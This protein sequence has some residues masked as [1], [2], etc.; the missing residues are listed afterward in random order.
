MCVRAL[1]HPGIGLSGPTEQLGSLRILRSAGRD[2]A[3]AFRDDVRAGFSASPKSLPP[4][5]FYDD[6]G[7]CLFEAICRLPEYYLTRAENEILREH[8]PAILDRA[9]RAS[10]REGWLIELGAGSAL[11]TR[12]LIGALMERGAPLHYVPIDIS[13]AELERT[14]RKLLGA[15]PTLRVT[16]VAAEFEAALT[17]LE[18][19]TRTRPAGTPTLALFLGSTIGNLEPDERRPFLSAVRRLLEP[20]DALLLGA[21]R[22]KPADEIVP[23]YDDALGVTAAFNLNVLARINRELGGAFDLRSFRHRALYDKE[24]GRI[25]MHIVSRGA[26]RV[27]IAA[28]G[29]DVGFLP[30]ESIHTENSYKFGV[31]QL[32]ALAADAQFEFEALW[33]DGA[34]RFLLTLLRAS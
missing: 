30:G 31:E 14:G 24:R 16:G 6:L 33:Q 13:A 3:A 29:M 8:T 5:Y 20:G 19:E 18:T 1:P 23:A 22:A 2:P 21:D 32:R 34:Q 10:G 28:L 11:K 9:W 26:Q 12:H 27:A 7:S 25:E 4:R 17:I 15:H